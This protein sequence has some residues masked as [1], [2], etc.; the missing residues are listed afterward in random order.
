M[1]T[2]LKVAGVV[3]LIAGA[4]LIILSIAGMWWFADWVSPP[5]VDFEENVLPMPWGAFALAQRLGVMLGGVLII[6]GG[7]ALFCLGNIYNDVRQL[8]DR[9]QP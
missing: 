3:V 7:A 1:G 9:L 8:K 5:G 4:A 6:L 2:F